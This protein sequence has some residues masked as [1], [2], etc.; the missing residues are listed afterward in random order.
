MEY[1]VSLGWLRANPWQTRLGIDEAYIQEL[2]A[3][4]E[5]RGLLQPPAGRIVNKDARP[6]EARL[7]NPGGNITD[8]LAA[9]SWFVELAFGHNRALAF[10]TLAEKDERWQLMPVR[11]VAF[12]D[13]EMANAAWAEN[14]QR[15]DLSPMEEAKA[16]KHRMN[17]FGWTQGEVAAA[18]GLARSTVANKLRILEMPAEIQ[19]ALEQRE[20]TERQA[21][22]IAPAFALPA[23]AVERAEEVTWIDSPREIRGKGAPGCFVGGPARAGA[24][25]GRGYDVS[26]G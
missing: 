10:H 11:I 5:R 22:A 18:L 15:K 24:P 14:A 3:D 19:A 9:A 8:Y 13:E 25:C 23:P 2:A 6:V 7:P 1:Q 16:I 12:T 17:S 21:L 4:I 20:I 26:D